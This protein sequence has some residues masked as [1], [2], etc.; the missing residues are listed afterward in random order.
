[1]KITAL[2]NQDS[3]SPCQRW[4]GG[5]P[6]QCNQVNRLREASGILI[7]TLLFF[8]IALAGADA[9]SRKKTLELKNGEILSIVSAKVDGNILVVKLEDGRTEIILKSFLS[10]REKFLYFGEASDKAEKPEETSQLEPAA[11]KTG[12]K[13][14]RP[15][16]VQ[17]VESGLEPGKDYRDYH[18]LFKLRV[19]DLHGGIHTEP[20]G[21]KMPYRYFAPE[22]ISPKTKVP[23]VLF[24]HGLGERGTD[25][26]RHLSVQPAP[27]IFVQP[28]VQKKYP[29]FFV[30]PQHP[31]GTYWCGGDYNRP[32]TVLR[33]AVAIVDELIEKYPAIDVERLYVTGLS[34]GGIGAWDAIAKFPGKFA[35]AAPISAG[36]DSK[37]IKEK[38]GVAVWAFYNKEEGAF[39]RDNCDL[40]LETVVEKGG[41][42]RKT[43]YTGRGHDAWTRAYAEPVLIKWLFKQRRYTP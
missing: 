20:D 42:A 26:G 2:K 23:L 15:L 30:A 33:M 16:T 32:S 34:S 8:G 31:N 22:N 9:P 28:Q 6:S 10:E 29:C 24:L 13:V 41:I 39:I 36:W 18:K 7:L 19:A 27:L 25:N 11:Q 14:L 1:M 5:V 17:L 43:I 12:A 37:M 21:A 3:K 40:M 4:K 35:G 38:Q